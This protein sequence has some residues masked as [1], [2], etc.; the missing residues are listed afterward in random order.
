MK[1]KKPHR[2]SLRPQKKR[3]VPPKDARWCKLFDCIEENG[4]TM[5]DMIAC[6]C[7]TLLRYPQNYYE[8]MININDYDFEVIIK[9]YMM[10]KD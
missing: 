6:A 3:G 4:F 5:Q 10:P 2:K 1:L 9:K 7:T 8:T